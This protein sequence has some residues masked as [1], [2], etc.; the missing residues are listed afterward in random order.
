[1]GPLSEK[2]LQSDIVLKELEGVEGI[3]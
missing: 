3:E 2:D 1:M